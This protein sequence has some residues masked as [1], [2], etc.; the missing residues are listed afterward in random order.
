MA[1]DRKNFSNSLFIT[2]NFERFKVCDYYSQH[3]SNRKLMEFLKLAIFEKLILTI[4][5]LY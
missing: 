1:T 2:N 5:E 3:S 4:I